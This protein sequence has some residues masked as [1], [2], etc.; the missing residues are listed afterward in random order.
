MKITVLPNA[1]KDT[2]LAV[3]GAAIGLL[4]SCG[5]EVFLPEAFA[6]RFDGC[7]YFDARHFPRCS[8]VLLVVGGD[9]SI[10][11]ASVYAIRFGI[12]VLG[13]NLGRLGYLSELE[14]GELP[15]LRELCRGAYTVRSRMTLQAE[16]LSP[17]G[18][19]SIRRM[20]VNDVVIGNRGAG[21]PVD[22]AVSDGGGDEI[23]YRADGLICATPTGSTAYSL[24]AGGPV[25]DAEV[26]AIC[27]TPI[28]PHSFFNRSV[29]FPAGAELR[30]RNASRAGHILTV[31]VDGRALNL[32]KPG[33]TLSVRRSRRT[34]G[35]V[36]FEKDGI[37]GALHDKMNASILK[38]DGK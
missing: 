3:T 32:L 37:L 15:R 25:I 4:R 38:A 29:L 11:D 20:A 33:E 22:L 36:S 23:L 7:A 27:L 28:C 8:D 6:G 2:D 31:S 13:I 17:T 18:K 10:L 26:E 9:G 19:K 14:V 21:C 35:T 16:I 1:V 30:I 34:L 24:S 5:A 12:P